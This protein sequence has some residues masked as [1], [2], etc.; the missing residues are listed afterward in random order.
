MWCVMTALLWVVTYKQ[1]QIW[2]VKFWIWWQ[3][4]CGSRTLQSSAAS[5]H[6]LTVTQS[7]GSITILLLLRTGTLHLLPHFRFIIRATTLDLESILILRSWP[8]WDPTMWVA[9]KFVWET[10]FG[11]QSPLT[12]PAS[13]LTWGT[14]C[15]PWQ[16][17][18]L[19]AW[20]TEPW[21]IQ[22]SPE[23][24]WPF[25][26]LHLF[27]HWSLLPQRWSH[28][29]GLLFTGHSLGLNTRKLH[30]LYGSE[31][32]VWTFSKPARTRKLKSDE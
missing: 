10:G 6:I 3:R 17:G 2:H 30:T 21:P 5:S 24:Q 7:S 27:M 32:V 14:C 20:D 18:G 4:D 12:P 31:T 25:L 9:S 16:M 8:S 15:R 19:W 29:R 22:T 28:L 1:L 23:C 13:V 26:E 11:S